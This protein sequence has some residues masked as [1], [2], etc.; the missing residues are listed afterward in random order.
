MESFG[1]SV[2][3]MLFVYAVAVV[4]SLI[5]AWIIKLIFVAI[6]FRKNGAASKHKSKTAD[7][8]VQKAS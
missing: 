1:G 4:I 6:Q 5:T 7:A 3:L 2:K 8:H